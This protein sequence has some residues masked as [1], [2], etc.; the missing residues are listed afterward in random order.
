ME[1]S[2]L[3]KHLCGH[4]RGPALSMLLPGLRQP[5][6]QD[7]G[8]CSGSEV[9]LRGHGAPWPPRMRRVPVLVTGSSSGVLRTRC[10]Q[11]TS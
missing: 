8:A 9:V 6:L 11:D 3:W 1:A 2:G 10:P 7:T 5:V 4:L